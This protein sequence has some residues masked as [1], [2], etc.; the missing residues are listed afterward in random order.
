MREQPTPDNSNKHVLPQPKYRR[1]ARQ[2]V[3]R[4]VAGEF[5]PGK[6]L[7]DERELAVQL[8][9]SRSTVRQAM[10]ILEQRHLVHRTR[11]R[12]TF[13]ANDYESSPWFSTATTILLAQIQENKPRIDAPGTY[14]GR[15][16]NGVRQ[17]A[18]SLGLTVKQQK[19]RGYVRVLLNDYEPPSADDVG[20]VVVSG[21]FDEQYIRMYQSEGIPV[22]AVDYWADDLI[23]DCVAIDVEAEAKAIAESVG[24]LRI[25]LARFLC[26][27]SAPGRSPLGIGSGCTTTRYAS[28][29]CNPAVRAPN[30]R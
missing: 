2:L 15:I 12:G 21:V 13:V 24:S 9:V 17:M 18:R 27:R 6:K 29:L 7:P 3:R 28:A 11:G 10:K 19:V 8:G 14:Y 4:I 1:L 25:Y 26:L 22:V 5:V 20:G 23:T 30:A 16:R